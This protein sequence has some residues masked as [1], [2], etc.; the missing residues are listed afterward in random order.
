LHQDVRKLFD[1]YNQK[2]PH[3]ALDYRTSEVVY[4]EQ[5]IGC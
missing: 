3:Q 4:W 5:Q 1:W 2:R